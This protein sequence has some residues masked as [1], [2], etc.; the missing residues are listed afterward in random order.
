M[1]RAARLRLLTVVV[2]AI[3]LVGSTLRSQPTA[4]ITSYQL[5]S[6]VR[7]TRTVSEYTYKAV[8]TNSGPP[9]GA[10]TATATSTSPNTTIVDNSL[11]FAPVAAG[12]TTVSTDTFSFRQNR[13][14]AFNWADIQWNIVSQAGNRPPVA[15]AG[16][17]QTVAPA[18]TATLNGSG[19]TDA[20]GD[21]LTFAWSFIARPA[22]SAATLSNPTGITP[23][24]A[25]DLPGDYVVGLVVND[26]SVNSAQDTITISTTNSPPAADAGPDRSAHVGSNV[27]LDGTGSSDADGNP[28]T[29]AWSVVSR[30]AGSAASINFPTS[31][32]PTFVPDVAGS[33]LIQL[34]VNDGLLTST[35]DTMMI[36][37]GNSPPVANAGPNQ[38]VAPGANVTLNG[39]TSTDVDGDPLSFAWSF[40]ARPA[41]SAAMLSN[42]AAVLPTFTADRPGDYLVQ[43]VVNDGSAASLPDTVLVS[44]T[45]S[46]PVANAGSD[47]TVAPG[48]VVSLDGT[49]SMDGDGD[50]LTFAWSF[51]SRPAGSAATLSGATAALPTFVADLPGTYVVQLIVNDGNVPS[52]P[53]TAT[54]STVNSAPS[55]NAG[56]DQLAVPA[57]QAV[58][59]FG[60][61]S[62]DPDGDPLTFAWS[63]T[64]RPPGSAAALTGA[65]T[66][67]PTFTP[68]V[69][70]VYVAQLIVN[71]GFTSS[72]PDTVLISAT[73]V[74]PQ[75]SVMASDATASEVGPDAATFTITRTGPTAAALTVQYSVD[76][77]A[78][79][80]NDYTPALSGSATIAA[81]LAS[82]AVTITPAN[83]GELEGSETVVLRLTAN[84]AYTVNAPGDATATI[85][86]NA[87]GGELVDGALQT[88]A[89][90]GAG[91]TDVWTFHANVGDRIAVHIGEIVDDNDFRPW[92]RLLA[93]TAASL[94]SSFGLRAAEI[95]DVIAPVTGT[96][97]VLVASADAGL[98]GTGTYRL[99]MAHT[100]GPV[101]V[102]PGD[103]GGPLGNGTLHT[104]AIATGDLDVWTFTATAG[105][106]IAVHIGEIV[107]NDDFRPW[108]RVW[109]PNGQSIGSAFGTDAAS[110]GDLI[111]P[112]AGNYLVLVAS[113]DPGV[114][115]AGAYRMTMTRSGAAVTVTAGDQG[116]PLGNG[117]LHTGEIVQGDLD[118]WTFT[119]I[120]GD[121]LAVHI[122]EMA[123]VDDF[124]PWI[125]IWAPS[126]QSLGS[127]FGLDAAEIGDVIAPVTGT[128]LVLVASADSGVD[129]TGTYRLTM[130]HTGALVT[131]SA[132]DQGGPLGNGTMHAGEIV[133]G[134]LDVWTF[135]ATAGERVAIHI[136]Q[137]AE[138]DDFRPW[139]RLWTPNGQTMGSAFGTDAAELGDVIL[140][141]T[142]TYSVLVASADA[143]VDGSGSYRL[144]LVRTGD[145]VSVSAGDEGGSLGNGTMHTGEIVPGD[146]DVWTFTAAVGDRVAVHIGE[147]ADNNYF[148]PWIR[149]WAP[150]GQSLGSAFGLDAAEIG[151][152]L[153][154]VAGTYFVVVGSADSGADGTGSY[155]LTLAH[156]GE[157][158]SVSA[159]DAGG[160]VGNGTTHAGTIVQGDADVWTFTATA[161][162][163]ISVHIAETAETDDFRPWI[164]VWTPNAAT[165]GSA[166]GLIVADL[167]GMTAPVTGTYFVIVG[168][169]DSGVDGTGTYN[170]VVTR[171]GS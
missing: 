101:T 77:T 141:S 30:P 129:G 98:D 123:D 33:Y 91:E 23:T 89:I 60:G 169:A 96:Y 110:L 120:A 12:G 134:D 153:A 21:P 86:D 4:G 170:L 135:A 63:L 82:V 36:D 74:V 128:Y 140:P 8:L 94:G 93:P 56:P 100:S 69:A 26:G 7:I 59:L 130:T 85:A 53:D 112:V 61:S 95:G 103:Q 57:G 114:D 157:A 43:L 124:R 165:L 156:T 38:T 31:V 126:G 92:I 40:V 19:S 20:D 17:D 73:V 149:V 84:S 67:T 143:G 167:N 64:T 80:G 47:Q 147:I 78:T 71:D 158:V 160:P 108:I 161:G 32:S 13:A 24:V 49:S 35:P 109:A 113:A 79:N 27:V 48:S 138:T 164:R 34:I 102:S 166:F 5:I 15:N 107:D 132:G 151:D 28:L 54:V 45:N 11:T 44:T 150:G 3:G 14:F 119:A 118:V 163:Q 90:V 104:G 97:Q 51:V 39:S 136:G 127:S 81:G 52:V 55:A 145:A 159:G 154:P 66:V 87:S 37:T 162:D 139:V 46:A 122:G 72:S 131:V 42:P 106:R 6:E 68:D 155:R 152:T 105:E 75:V 148:R 133:Q 115:G 18:S 29:F 62:S 142:G 41:G 2:L 10:S 65:A 83:D 25:V 16:P 50:P 117:T 121:R 171:S 99:T 58:T 88:G 9:L 76:G 1:T 22:G 144:T 111:A 137:I 168:S 70:G 125:R 146:L 116:G